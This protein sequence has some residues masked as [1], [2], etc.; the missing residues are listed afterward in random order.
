MNREAASAS[1]QSCSEFVTNGLLNGKKKRLWG[2]FDK[3]RTHAGI[4]NQGFSPAALE[5][6]TG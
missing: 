1:P 6:T 2:Q 5:L 4:G 3:L